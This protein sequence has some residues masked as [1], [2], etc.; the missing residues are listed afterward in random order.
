MAR[1]LCRSTQG[2][3]FAETLDTSRIGQVFYKGV[4]IAIDSYSTFFDNYNLRAT[5]LDDFLKHAQVDEVYFAGLATD[6]CVL[7]SVKDA[8]ALGFETFVIIDCCRDID[9]TLVMYVVLFLRCKNLV[10]R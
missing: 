6:Y 5:G 3:E 10:R 9:L 4:D 1:S 8:R 2:A 7:Y